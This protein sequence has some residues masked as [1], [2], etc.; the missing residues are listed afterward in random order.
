[1]AF[2]SWLK[3]FVNLFYPYSCVLCGHPL[4]GNEEI[5]C[6]SCILD[7][8]RTHF[9]TFA[10]NET[11][12]RFWGRIDLEHAASFLFFHK[13]SKY[14][15]LIHL[16]KYNN[17]PEI[18]VFLGNLYGQELINTSFA[19]AD[20]IIPVPLHPKK[21]KIRGYNQAEKF[22]EGLSRQLNIPVRNELKRIKFTETQTKKD[23]EERW[24]N[25]K[26]V[27]SPVNCKNLENKHVI[28]V[29]DVITTGATLEACA[30][31][32]KTCKNVKISILTVGIAQ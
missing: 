17:K 5:L 9:H 6:A 29:D 31:A 30:I 16:L 19:N 3:D 14:Q 4:H 32:L 24:N 2:F 13:G 27:F 23:K 7:M 8:P 11:A 20:M 18:G 15:K 28:L 25:V 10:N 22:A 26:N 12:Q 1:M 21:E